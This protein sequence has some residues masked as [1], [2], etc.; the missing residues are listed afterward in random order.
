MHLG[1]TKRLD[2][3]PAASTANKT[4]ADQI[5]A[6]TKRLDRRPAAST[7][8]KTAADQI[9]ALARSNTFFDKIPIPFNS[10]RITVDMGVAQVLSSR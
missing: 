10:R 7:A 1:L 2:R 8:N 9:R 5:R 4:A 3:R 6:L